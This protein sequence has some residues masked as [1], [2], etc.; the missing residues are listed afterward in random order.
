MTVIEC[1]K[2]RA[3]EEAEGHSRGGRREMVTLAPLRAPL[4]V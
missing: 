4:D 3:T 1:N 2:Q